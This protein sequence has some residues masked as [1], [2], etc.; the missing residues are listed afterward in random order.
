MLKLSLNIKDDI[1]VELG[2]DMSPLEEDTTVQEASKVD[3]SIVELEGDNQNCERGM[4]LN[5]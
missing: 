5:P 1:T 2:I 4:Y 3:E